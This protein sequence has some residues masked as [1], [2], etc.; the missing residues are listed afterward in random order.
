MFMDKKG[1]LNIVKMSVL[2]NLIYTVNII[3]VKIPEVIFGDVEKLILK[4]IWRGKRPRKAN[5]ILQEKNKVGGPTLLNFMTCYKATAMRPNGIGERIDK[6][7]N[8][9]E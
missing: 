4:F 7:I 1:R 9:K 6:Y 3:P 2:L 8:R 5:T